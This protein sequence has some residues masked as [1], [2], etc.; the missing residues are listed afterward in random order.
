MKISWENDQP[1]GIPR[2]IESLLLLRPFQ[3]IL[4]VDVGEYH[5]KRKILAYI[6]SATSRNKIQDTSNDGAKNIQSTFLA[7]KQQT[8][9]ELY[10]CKGNWRMIQENVQFRCILC[11]LG[12]VDIMDKQLNRKHIKVPFLPLSVHAPCTT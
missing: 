10:M 9:L 3:N 11:I 6:T 1:V 5:K 8:M 12:Y 2:F 7:G 4:R